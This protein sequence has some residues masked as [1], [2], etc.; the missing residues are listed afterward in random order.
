MS[1]DENGVLLLGPLSQVGFCN[2]HGG[3]VVGL[4]NRQVLSG[5][6]YVVK[7]NGIQKT[8]TKPNVFVWFSQPQT[9]VVGRFWSKTDQ[10]QKSETVTTLITRFDTRDVPSCRDKS[11]YCLTN[12]TNFIFPAFL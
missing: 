12:L 2:S 11:Y 5:A 9:C 7:W 4:S 6:G 8:K 10:Q 1:T 3:Y